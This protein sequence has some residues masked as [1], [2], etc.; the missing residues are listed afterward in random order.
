[1][2]QN[3]KDAIT[4]ILSSIVGAFVAVLAILASLIFSVPLLALWK[5]SLNYLMAGGAV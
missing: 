4:A 3:I 5:L 2:N 1:M